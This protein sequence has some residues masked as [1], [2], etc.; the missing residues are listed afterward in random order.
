MPLILLTA[1]E[2]LLLI[3]SVYIAANIR[4]K[5]SWAIAEN[6]ESLPMRATVFAGVIL[7]CMVTMGLFQSRLRERSTGIFIRIVASFVAGV[8]VL[9]LLF[10]VYPLLYLGRGILGIAL[11]ISFVAIVAAHLSFL[12]FAQDIMWRRVVVIGAGKRAN[13]LAKLRRRSDL[14]GL[15]LIG[16]IPMEG[17]QT[18]VEE[19]R[20]LKVNGNLQ[21]YAIEQGVNEYV[22]AVDDRRKNF[23]LDDLLDCKMAGVHV[24]DILTV[25]EEVTGKIRLDLINPSWMV[26][27][28]GFENK[29]TRE[30]GKRIF[31]LLSAIVVLLVAW[32]FMLITAAAIFIESGFKGPI[33]YSQQRIGLGGHAFNVYKFRSMTVDA[34]QNGEAQWAQ[35]K[36]ARVTKVGNIIRLLRIDELPQIF[37]VLKGSMSFVGP[38][39]ERPV[40]VE[41][42]SESIPYYGK[43]H[44]VK[45]G[46]SGWAQLCYPYGSSEKDAKEKLQFDLYYIKNHSLFLDLTILLHTVEVVLFGKGAR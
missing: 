12:H 16:F 26:F 21:E 30:I 8:V 28:D 35:K 41:Q 9:A 15:K 3:G 11:V 34:E 31:D 33:F 4:F 40:F 1:I 22:V 17:E 18:E 5:D 36:D 43:R 23:P 7:I 45:P 42:L 13:N 10:Y 27:S 14:F 32:P 2:F 29:P 44:Q 37:N 20:L 46:I 38:R 25:F 19:S 6:I 39:P 24:S